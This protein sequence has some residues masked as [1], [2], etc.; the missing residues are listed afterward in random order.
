MNSTTSSVL[1]I[2]IL[3]AL[4]PVGFSQ[5][6]MVLFV[7]ASYW[8]VKAEQPIHH[9][10]LVNVVLGIHFGWLAVFVIIDSVTNIDFYHMQEWVGLPTFILECLLATAIVLS[11]KGCRAWNRSP[12]HCCADEHV[13]AQPLETGFPKEEEPRR[14]F[15]A[16]RLRTCRWPAIAASR[17]VDGIG[18][19]SIRPLIATRYVA[20]SAR[21]RCRRGQG[22]VQLGTG[23]AAEPAVVRGGWHTGPVLSPLAHEVPA[24]AQA[25]ENCH[26]PSKE[27]VR[28]EEKG[29]S[30]P[31]QSLEFLVSG[32]SAWRRGMITVVPG[33]IDSLQDL[34]STGRMLFKLADTNNDNF[35][36]QKE[37]TTRA[38]C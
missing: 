26:G 33:P 1:A 35:I 29:S 12:R 17:P 6:H 24:G 11:A 30:G 8:L 32:S 22:S 28:C 34:E 5:Y 15:V 14:F 38:T 36:S 31:Q 9:R 25:S 13:H 19:T 3:V 2:L 37:A 20:V 23:V 4:Y 18:Q 7:L 27:V 10:G 16:A 21:W